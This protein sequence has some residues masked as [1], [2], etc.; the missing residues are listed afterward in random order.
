MGSAH[1]TLLS[2]GRG[3]FDGGSFSRARSGSRERETCE[4]CSGGRR[5]LVVSGAKLVLVSNGGAGGV[6]LR[7]GVRI[8]ENG[9]ANGGAGGLVAHSGNSKPVPVDGDISGRR[10]ARVFTCTRADGVE[11]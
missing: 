2:C 8:H 11:L 7:A 6:I 4:R 10:L 9:R 5:R 1:R 3:H